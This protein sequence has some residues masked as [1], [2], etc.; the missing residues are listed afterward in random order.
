MV[1]VVML[2]WLAVGYCWRSCARD[3]GVRGGGAA[4]ELLDQGFGAE[5]ELVV[6]TAGAD[7]AGGDVGVVWVG[8]RVD[9]ADMVS[10]GREG[11]EV[12]EESATESRGCACYENMVFFRWRRW[13]RS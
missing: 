10:C 12:L 5:V 9:A 3:A 11:G 13:R 7:G 4:D 2:V 6:V 1:V 8:S